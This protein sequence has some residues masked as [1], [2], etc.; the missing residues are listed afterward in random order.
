MWQNDD[1]SNAGGNSPQRYPQSPSA[2]ANFQQ[3]GS[4][5]S[6]HQ[7]QQQQHA[8]INGQQTNQQINVKVGNAPVPPTAPRPKGFIEPAS[9]SAVKERDALGAKALGTSI[10]SEIDQI[11]HA[12]EDVKISTGRLSNEVFE[13]EKA[14]TMLTE[15]YAKYHD[16]S[17]QPQ[18]RSQFDEAIETALLVNPEEFQELVTPQLMQILA[19]GSGGGNLN[20]GVNGSANMNLDSPFSSAAARTTLHQQQQRVGG[21]PRAPNGIGKALN[22]SSTRDSIQYTQAPL[23]QHAPQQQSPMLHRLNTQVPPGSSS[24]WERGMESPAAYVAGAGGEEK[25]GHMG[26]SNVLFSPPGR[27][28]GGSNRG[29]QNPLRLGGTSSTG[30]GRG[31]LD[32]GMGGFPPQPQHNV[33][34]G[35]KLRT[36]SQ[37]ADAKL[38]QIQGGGG[39]KGIPSHGPRHLQSPNVGG[40]GGGGMSTSPSVQHKAQL[41]S[42]AMSRESS[43][44]SQKLFPSQQIPPQQQY[45]HDQIPPQ[46]MGGSDIPIKQKPGMSGHGS[47]IPSSPQQQLLQAKS[48]GVGA[49]G[50]QQ[51]KNNVQP[52]SGAGQNQTISTH[53][54][55]NSNG[56]LQDVYVRGGRPDTQSFPGQEPLDP[57]SIPYNNYSCRRESDGSLNSFQFP[58][59]NDIFTPGIPRG[60]NLLST[61]KHKDVVTAIT[62]S[63]SSDR[64]YAGGKGSVTVWDISNSKQPVA[65]LPCLPDNYIRSCKLL[66][67]DRTL[68]VGG[69]T[70]DL[71][72]WDLHSKQIVGRLESQMSGRME[73]HVLACY[74]LAVTP[75][76]VHPN[77]LCYSCSSDGSVDIWDIHNRSM[78]GTLKGHTDGV[79]CVDIT[80]DGTTLVTGGLDNMVKVWD[81]R[82]NKELETFRFPAHVF[83]IGVYGETPFVAVGIENHE[84]EIFSLTGEPDLNFNLRLHTD[85]VLS[86]KFA[87]K[88]PWFISTDKSSTMNVWRAPYGNCMF[89][90]KGPAAITS[91]DISQD[92]RIIATGSGEKCARVYEVT[93]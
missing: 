23:Y 48:Q 73:S 2:P 88:S 91:C 76:A 30:M 63:H 62:I 90:K 57:N 49:T 54:N 82:T 40:L 71:C 72:I 75:P 87:H 89:Q 86:L 29:S 10:R 69:E 33:S 18:H 79:S 25:S 20:T 50:Q 6:F 58:P 66:A 46:Q 52:G 5:G 64:I 19:I 36:P 9:D 83:S 74:A 61:L 14:N 41:A 21:T 80:S 59:Y 11:V 84:I 47:M 24:G 28:M 38:K 13:L 34:Q 26:K 78:L 22:P 4:N 56:N 3:T 85:S 32:I 68:I 8:N 53:M 35:Q 44:T 51:G 67:D 15:L 43:M 77:P 27:G 65:E 1:G 55:M 70:S 60:A 81:L 16:L 7:S 31:G 93:F 12:Y 39:A 92:D 42:G 45:N 37:H 17:Y